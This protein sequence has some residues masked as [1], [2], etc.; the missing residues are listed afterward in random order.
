[1]LA[2]YHTHTFRC[3]HASGEDKEYVEAAIRA[4]MKVLGFSDHCP[5]IFDNGYIS[6]MRMLPQD[7]DDYFDSL[8]RLKQEYSGDITI[9]IGFE[10]EYFP[11]LID[12]QTEF[13]KD[14]PLD[15]M[16]LGQHFINREPM[17]GAGNPTTD[18]MILKKYVDNVIE[19]METGKYQYVAHPD[20]I[21]YI[22]PKG[23]YE[24]HMKRLCQY[25]K[26]KNIPIEIN[27][28]GLSG[29]RHYPSEHFLSIAQK[30]GNSA[31]IGIDAHDP[32]RL[33][34]TQLQNKCLT[35]VKKYNLPLM[36]FLPN[37]KAI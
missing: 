2:N 29:N 20:L 8:Q 12:A 22:G 30:T 19:G 34:N 17:N 1:M 35:L 5:W 6:G 24:Y 32:K 25:L 27:L 10:A 18:E 36:D 26:D 16:I 3:N 9:Y 11:E 33:E 15:Y 37:L 4:G 7:I 23:I 13:F 28:Q 31:I 21:N 14:Y